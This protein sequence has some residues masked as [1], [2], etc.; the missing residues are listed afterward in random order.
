MWTPD[1]SIIEHLARVEDYQVPQTTY[2]AA[3]ERW[4]G[5]AFTLRQGARV[6]ENS[7]RTRFASWAD[8]RSTGKPRQSM[9]DVVRV[10]GIR[11]SERQNELESCAGPTV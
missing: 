1:A 10:C 9:A 11:R 7:R 2:R 4:P 6:I 8:N 3:V 5:G